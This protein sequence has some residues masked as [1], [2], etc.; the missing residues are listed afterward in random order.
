MVVWVMA[1]VGV[2]SP[3]LI[4]T[5]A[6]GIKEFEVRNIKSHLSIARQVFL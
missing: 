3:I 5:D 1:V 4:D 2:F 6:Q